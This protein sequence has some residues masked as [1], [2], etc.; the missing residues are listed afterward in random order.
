MLVVAVSVDKESGQ[1]TDMVTS[2]SGIV[3]EG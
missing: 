3:E 2:T 1:S